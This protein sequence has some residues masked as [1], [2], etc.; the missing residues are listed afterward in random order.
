MILKQLIKLRVHLNN[1]R[2]YVTVL[3][4]IHMD[5]INS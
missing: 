5:P 2:T 1:I 3:E 4:Y